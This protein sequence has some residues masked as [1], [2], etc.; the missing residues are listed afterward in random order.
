MQLES[1]KK[2]LNIFFAY[3]PTANLNYI[4]FD[5]SLEGPLFFVKVFNKASHQTVETY[6]RRYGEL[7]K[8]YCLL[9]QAYTDFDL[10]I[11]DIDNEN[12]SKEKN[13]N[14][15]KKDNDEGEDENTDNNSILDTQ[16]NINTYIDPAK[17]EF[18]KKFG[19]DNNTSENFVLDA[20]SDIDT[21]INSIKAEEIKKRVRVIIKLSP[22][23][24]IDLKLTSSL[25]INYLINIIFA[26]KIS[27]LILL[28]K[29]VL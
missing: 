7:V 25:T 20:Q 22:N 24:I 17:L 14:E 12:L 9:S 28:I 5:K 27:Y 3:F 21:D 18:E 4:M 29:L 11:V 1:R 6:Y 23:K 10:N 2:L 16:L 8:D 26:L 15:R 19:I 13:N